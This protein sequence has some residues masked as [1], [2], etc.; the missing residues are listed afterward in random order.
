MKM[1]G[2]VLAVLAVAG[3]AATPEPMPR[4]APVPA[5]VLCALPEGQAVPEPEPE[6][7][8]GSYTQ[9][10]VALYIERLH[11]WGS[12][13]WVRLSAAREWSENCVDRAAVR[14]SGATR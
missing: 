13:G 4:P 8:A 14:D 6:R 7:P 9:R 11:R 12:R 3:C 10:D 1:I 5:P 2:A